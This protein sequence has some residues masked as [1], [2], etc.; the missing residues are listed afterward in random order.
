MTASFPHLQELQYRTKFLNTC[1]HLF[2][3]LIFY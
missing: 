3:H 1:I 2:N